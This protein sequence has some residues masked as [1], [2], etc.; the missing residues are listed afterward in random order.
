MKNGE[1]SPGDLLLMV[2]C[3]CCTQPMLVDGFIADL[4]TAE[5]WGVSSTAP[6]R[7][8]CERMG[9]TASPQSLYMFC[10]VYLLRWSMVEFIA[11]GR[12]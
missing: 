9:E 1:G 10:F 8:N 2:C 3:Y 5:N 11:A 12:A 4:L 6:R 7:G